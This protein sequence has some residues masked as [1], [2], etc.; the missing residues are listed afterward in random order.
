MLYLVQTHYNDI[1]G[2]LYKRI[3]HSKKTI[4]YLCN[5]IIY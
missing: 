5:Y 3:I 2:E 4:Q 1:S